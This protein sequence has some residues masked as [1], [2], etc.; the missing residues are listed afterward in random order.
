[1]KRLITMPLCWKERIFL[2]YSDTLPENFE[3]NERKADWK[4]GNR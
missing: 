3:A 1:M 2:R 4:H